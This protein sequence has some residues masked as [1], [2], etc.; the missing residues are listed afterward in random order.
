VM[1]TGEGSP[2]TIGWGEFA[3]REPEL[4]NFGAD[5]LTAAP[6]YLATVRRTGTP[7]VHP[8]TPIFTAEGLFLFME[9]TSPKGRDLRER[10][11]FALH[12][13]VP[14]NAGTGG[15]FYI[16]GFGHVVDDIDVWSHVADAASYAPADRYILFEFRLSEANCNGYGDVALPSTRSWSVDQ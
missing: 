1:Q 10:G 13:G 5:R 3:R 14:D 8:V 6:A 12:N 16:S 2:R 7:R 9:P 11:W 15:E 4:A